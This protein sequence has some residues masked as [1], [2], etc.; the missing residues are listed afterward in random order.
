MSCTNIVYQIQY[1]HKKVAVN[2]NLNCFSKKTDSILQTKRVF[3]K[4]LIEPIKK[5]FATLASPQLCSDN[6]EIMMIMGAV[7]VTL[8][9]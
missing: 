4:L 1:K 9:V 7:F 6:K 5:I 8:A 2:L 3:L